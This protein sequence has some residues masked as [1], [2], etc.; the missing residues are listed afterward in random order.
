M[1]KFTAPQIDQHHFTREQNNGT[2]Q[3]AHFS[4]RGSD[5]GGGEIM[6]LLAFNGSGGGA[7]PTRSL[8]LALAH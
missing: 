4:P 6:R 3:L 2:M 8:T 5:S 7:L 1:S